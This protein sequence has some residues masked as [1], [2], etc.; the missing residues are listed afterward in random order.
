MAYAIAGVMIGLFAWV[1]V[2]IYFRQRNRAGETTSAGTGYLLFGP[3]FPLIDKYFSKRDY[4]IAN[5]EI[6]AFAFLVLFF[7]GVA[8]LVTLTDI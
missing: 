2:A 8:L 1:G 4:Q 6:W 3:L 5:R 7:I